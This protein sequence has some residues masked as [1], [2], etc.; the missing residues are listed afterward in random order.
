MGQLLDVVHGPVLVQL[1]FFLQEHL[2]LI[3]H[4]AS[5]QQFLPLC[6]RLGSVLRETEREVLLTVVQGELLCYAGSSHIWIML[7]F[8]HL[9]VDAGACLRVSLHKLGWQGSAQLQQRV[10]L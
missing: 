6:L 2:L 4:P 9:H 3:G 8:E 1:E 5:T 7:V 10:G